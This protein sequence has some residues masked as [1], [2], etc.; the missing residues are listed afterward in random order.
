MSH[1][2]VWTKVNVKV[3]KGVEGI[4]SALSNFPRLQT[5]SS[6]ECN[7]LK[8][9]MIFFYYG[10]CYKELSDFVLRYFAPRLYAIVS[11]AVSIKI[12]T[13]TCPYNVHGELHVRAEAIS[14]IEDA[15]WEISNDFIFSLHHNLEY[16]DGILDKDL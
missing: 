14:I 9:P 4:V 3:D 15:I 11:D 13:T 16:Y 5:Y 12:V 6:C 8:G 7:S 10:E 2:Q 1:E